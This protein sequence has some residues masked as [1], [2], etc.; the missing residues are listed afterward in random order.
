ILPGY[1]EGASR[2]YTSRN[3]FGV[4]KVL[5]DSGAH[6]RKLV[7]GDTIHGI[8]STEPGR[9]GRPL[10]YYYPGGSVS[11]VIET[12]RGRE[13][14]Q[15]FAVMGWA[16]EPWRRSATLL[17]TCGSMRS[18]LLSNA[19]RGNISR[20]YL[21]A[22]RIATSLLAMVDWLSPANPI[23]RSTSFCSTHSA[24]IP[25]RRILF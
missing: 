20:S 6:L 11:D 22:V 10:S 9:S 4:K 23:V 7:H 12:L 14:P 2:I 17:T 3:F 1:I 19:S 15:Q 24:P 8:E 5:E 25:F 18:I 21:A 16:Q 13:T